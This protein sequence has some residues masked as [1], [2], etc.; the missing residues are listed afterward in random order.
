[1]ENIWASQHCV[2]HLDLVLC[3]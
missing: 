3:G 1:M 2:E